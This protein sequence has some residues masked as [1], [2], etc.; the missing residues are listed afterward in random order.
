M[1]RLLKLALL[2]GILSVLFVVPAFAQEITVQK[3]IIPEEKLLAELNAHNIE[4]YNQ[5]QAF[6]KTQVDSVAANAHAMVVYNQLKAY[7]KDRANNFIN[8]KKGVVYNLKEVERIK[9][10]IV[11]NYQWLSQYNPYFQTLIP[12]PCCGRPA[13]PARSWRN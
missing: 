10:E 1:K 2:T 6:M 11:T 13:R 12:A 8:Y 3:D 4:V 7:N 5:L 9:K